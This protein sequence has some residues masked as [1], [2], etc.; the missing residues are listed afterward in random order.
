MI[1]DTIQMAVEIDNHSAKSAVDSAMR[2]SGLTVTAEMLK[3]V[4]PEEVQVN[5]VSASLPS[6]R[7]LLRVASHAWRIVDVTVS[8]LW[9]GIRI[10]R[11]T[12]D[13]IVHV[14]MRVHMRVCA[15]AC[16]CGGSVRAGRQQQQQQHRQIRH[17]RSHQRSVG[18]TERRGG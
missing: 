1:Q 17:G 8:V 16:A 11:M 9:A 6:A 3:G 18:E 13:C 4:A 14:H 15:C 10:Q 2:R 5:V 12:T 7:L